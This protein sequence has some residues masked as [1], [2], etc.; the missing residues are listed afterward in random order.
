MKRR[1]FLKGLGGITVFSVLPM[2]MVFN[3]EARWTPFDG[4]KDNK[5]EKKRNFAMAIIQDNCIGCRACESACRSEWNIPDDPQSY[6]TKVLY[7]GEAQSKSGKIS[8]LPVLCNQCDNPPCVHGCP[9]RAS[10]KNKEDGIVLIDADKCIG[11]K[12]CIVSCPYEARY[13]NDKTSSVDKCTFC[14]PRIEK[15]IQPACVKACPL[16]ARVFGDLNEPHSEIS[17]L[18]RH[19]V[20][21]HVLK[22]EEGTQPNVFYTQNNVNNG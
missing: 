8:W 14:R 20:S 15:G 1:N 16:N 10:Y 18:L 17:D 2:P 21:Y 3:K 11:C 4:L 7:D 5:P 22:P 12:T 13:Y 19:A 6:R 9:T